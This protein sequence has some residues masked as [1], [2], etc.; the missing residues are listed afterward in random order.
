MHLD[1][2]YLIPFI[3]Q[4]LIDNIISL[5]DLL[6]RMTLAEKITQLGNTAGSIDRLDIPAYQWQVMMDV[7]IDY[8]MCVGG[9]IFL[10]CFFCRWSEGL[11]GVADSPGVHFN[12][13]VCDDC[14]ITYLNIYLSLFSLRMPHHFHKSLQPPPHS[15]SNHI[16]LYLHSPS[17]LTS[18]S[19]PPFIFFIIK[20]LACSYYYYIFLST[21]RTLF[22]EIAS[23]M[24]TEARAFANQGEAGLTYFTPNINII[25]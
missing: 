19:L 9:L 8:V 1:N 14:F 22:Y 20:Q 16:T 25:R 7:N 2:I 10:N 6:S 12:G 11:H 15:T 24:S 4:S 18:P 5:A 21:H 17:P 23:A 13:L 3:N